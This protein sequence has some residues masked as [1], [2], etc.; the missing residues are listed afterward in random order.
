MQSAEG[1]VD[2]LGSGL[3]QSE[4]LSRPVVRST[5]LLQLVLNSN[6]VVLLPLPDQIGELFS[7]QIVSRLL[8][9]G[10]QHLLNNRLSRDTGVVETGDVKN[11]LSLHSVESNQTI[12]KGNGETMSNMESSSDVRRRNGDDVET[13]V[14]GRSVGLEL[15]LK[16]S[17]LLPPLVP[18]R[19]DC[20]RVVRLESR[21][22]QRHKNLLLALDSLVDKLGN[23]LN[24][25]LCLLRGSLL[26]GS[27]LLSSLFGVELGQL[28]GLLSLVFQ[29]LGGLGLGLSCSRSGSGGCADSLMYRKN[30]GCAIPCLGNANLL[31]D[32]RKMVY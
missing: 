13:L 21:I 27:V 15:R 26:L 29:L 30:R 9:L 5:E 32:V 25:L 10:P 19:F 28:L 20:G 7:A 16:V 23:R 31:S 8:F 18:R 24:L 22:I 2:S 12:L 17:L 6:V 3:V 1:F 14:L 11:S 4:G